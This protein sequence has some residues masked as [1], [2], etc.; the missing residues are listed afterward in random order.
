MLERCSVHIQDAARELEEFP[1]S[2]RIRSRI[3][4]RTMLVTPLLWQGAAIGVIIIRRMQ[5]HPF[6]DTQIELLKTFADQSAIAIENTR[7]FHELR[8]RNQALTEALDQQTASTR[9]P[10]CDQQ[11]ADQSPARAG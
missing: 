4:Y 3:G 10:A 1:D 11:L 6:S 7:L 2:K 8:A 5:M 9:D